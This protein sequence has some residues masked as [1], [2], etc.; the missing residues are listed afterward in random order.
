WGA[1]AP[2]DRIIVTAAAPERPVDLIDQLVTG[3]LLIAPI[4][5]GGGDQHLVRYTKTETAFS[6][7]MLL[8]V[9]FIP[10]QSGI[11]KQD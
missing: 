2:F 8:P 6:E 1:Q 9:R 7:K 5:V 4:E 3:G 11:A 10:L